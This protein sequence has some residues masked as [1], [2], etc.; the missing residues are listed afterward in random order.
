MKNLARILPFTLLLSAC[1]LLLNACGDD[2]KKEIKALS[3]E[4]NQIHDEAMKEMAEMNR[5]AR[6]LK[7]TMISAT[8]L[9]EQSEV[10]NKTLESMGKAENGMMDWMKNH[11]SLDEIPE[12]DA[13]AY[14]KEQK[15]SIEKNRA[16]IQ[17][18]IQAGKQLQAK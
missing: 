2:H 14:L 6:E 4:T 5:I 13:L 1:F 12:K 9:P 3:E 7:Q 15:A 17:A 11:K 8:M 10:Y 18:A 16:D